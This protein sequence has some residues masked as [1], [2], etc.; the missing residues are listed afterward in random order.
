MGSSSAATRQQIEQTVI[1]SLKLHEAWDLL[2]AMKKL[3]AE[4]N[5]RGN[6]A[7][8]IL[9]T[10]PQLISAMYEIHKRLGIAL[11]KNVQQQQQQGS[12]TAA[13]TSSSKDT[14][15]ADQIANAAPIVDQ[16]DYS[17]R[18][19]PREQYRNNNSSN[20]WDSRVDNR[21]RDR[22]GWERE[23]EQPALS[24]LPPSSIG[25]LLCLL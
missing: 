25:M 2:D 15:T 3:V 5:N 6:K 4:D 9:E 20:D 19:D 12:T 13:D 14:R 22:D 11:P 18:W 8:A 23:W 7:K 24:N 1:N 17:S 16:R 10:H 21:D